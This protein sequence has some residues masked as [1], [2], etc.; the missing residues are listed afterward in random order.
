M[1]EYIYIRIHEAY[2][3][4]NACKLGKTCC[5]ISRHKS[6]STH[7]ILSGYFEVVFEVP[8]INNIEKILQRNFQKFHI[9]I[10][11]GNEF[12]DK[13]I[14]NLIE[15]YIDTLKILYKKIN[16]EDIL[17]L[18]QPKHGYR[19]RILLPNHIENIFVSNFDKNEKDYKKYY[20]IYYEKNINKILD[21]KIYSN[22]LLLKRSIINYICFYL[23]IKHSQDYNVI[24]KRI[25]VENLIYSCSEIDLE[26]ISDIFKLRMRK[27]SLKYNFYI[28]KDTIDFI[29][30]I[31][32]TWGFS[33]IVR[34]K[35]ILK[36]IKG[37]RVDISDYV[38]K[39]KLDIDI[40]SFI[41]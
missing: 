16:K 19:N 22:T 27:K 1:T 41:K 8:I 26:K 38:L 28:L 35:K 32:T 12:Y 14:I 39:N 37:K 15:S 25:N 34:G 24:I 21:V 7:E 10:N 3:K 2:D 17:K 31:F 13:K 36:T 23:N 6:Y 4:Y 29:N 33:T 11:A 9:K 18:S 20:N 40:Y 5:F 30:N